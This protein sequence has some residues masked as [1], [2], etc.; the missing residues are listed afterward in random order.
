MRNFVEQATCIDQ[1]VQSTVGA[2]QIVE[3]YSFRGSQVPNYAA[4]NLFGLD[5][6]TGVAA[7]L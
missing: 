2:D 1:I 4:M 6:G 5:W 7:E 3:Q